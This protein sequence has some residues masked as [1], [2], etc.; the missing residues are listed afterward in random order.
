MVVEY[1]LLLL[2]SVIII[3]APFMQGEG[4]VS[5]MGTSGPRLGMRVERALVTGEGFQQRRSTRLDWRRR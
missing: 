1:M 5:M 2:V 4:P 3:L